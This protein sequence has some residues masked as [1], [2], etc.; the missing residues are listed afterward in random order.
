[1]LE[2]LSEGIME[3]GFLIHKSHTLTEV[4]RFEAMLEEANEILDRIERNER[5]I[6]NGEIIQLQVILKSVKEI[7]GNEDLKERFYFDIVKIEEKMKEL[8]NKFPSNIYQ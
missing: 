8:F 6:S 5:R 3:R 1:M 7:L 2:S 4:Y